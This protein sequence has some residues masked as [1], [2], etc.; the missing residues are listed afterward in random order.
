MLRTLAL[1]CAALL[2]MALFLVSTV[3][4][5]EAAP[6]SAIEC[7]GAATV[8]TAPTYVEF[9][10]HARSVGATFAEAA[11][12][13]LTFEQSLRKEL[14]TRQL[15][16]MD[17]SMSNLAIP[18]SLAREANISARLRF[19]AVPLSTGETGPQK[20]AELCDKVVDI[21]NALGCAFSG[22]VLGTEDTTAVEEAAIARAIEK[23]Y[24]SAK[25]A[26][27]IMRG[28]IVAVDRVSVVDLTWNKA[29]DS[30]AVQP[31]IRRLT[32]TARVRVSYAFAAS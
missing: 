8:D 6:L 21:S 19:N 27:Q 3:S 4:A 17:L 16:F 28:Q 20:F 7:D 18:N 29:P 12:K 25:A 1:Y 2:C 31:D 22:P 13:T 30:Q 23:A 5:Q 32:C 9:W 15:T 14:E 26:A 24:P 11:T 10:L